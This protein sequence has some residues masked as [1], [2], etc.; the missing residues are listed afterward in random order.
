MATSRCPKGMKYWLYDPEDGVTFFDNEDELHKAAEAAVESYYDQASGWDVEGVKGL[1]GGI[2]THRAEVN[3]FIP[4]PPEDEIDEEGYDRDGEWWDPNWP[5][6][7]DFEW[8]PADLEDA[9]E[10]TDNG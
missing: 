3:L 9:D 8:L 2:I 7:M 10:E 6:I 5:S 1:C 4:R